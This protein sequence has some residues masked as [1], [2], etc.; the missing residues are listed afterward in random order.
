MITIIFH[1]TE[2]TAINTRCNASWTFM[3]LTHASSLYG[4]L[5]PY[6]C[7]KGCILRR[8]ML[9][10]CGQP[11][12][13]GNPTWNHWMPVH[14]TKKKHFHLV[15][16]LTPSRWSHVVAN[17]MRCSTIAKS[18]IMEARW[19]AVKMRTARVDNGFISNVYILQKHNEVCGVVLNVWKVHK[20]YCLCFLYLKNNSN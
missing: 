20:T 16:L 10:A 2:T 8:R 14:K 6:F 4:P 17:I 1:W 3:R 12:R 15:Q 19:Y 18:P 11:D 9:A 7:S 5:T 13:E